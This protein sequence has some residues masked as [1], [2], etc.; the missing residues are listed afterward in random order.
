MESDLEKNVAYQKSRRKSTQDSMV[1]FQQL[2]S[3]KITIIVYSFN[4]EWII[5]L[6]DSIQIIR[7]MIST[8]KKLT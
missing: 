7:L 5:Q 3:Q 6:D 1:F 4:F 2:I 8:T